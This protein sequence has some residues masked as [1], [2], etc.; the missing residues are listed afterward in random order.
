MNSNVKQPAELYEQMFYR[1]LKNCW[2]L[3]SQHEFRFKNSLYSLDASAIDLS[4]KMFPRAAHR[5]DTANV[6]LSI[7]LNHGTQV[8]EFVAL[9]D[10]Q[11]N[12][13]V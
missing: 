1:L 7:G 11:E 9:S 10:G 8:P 3:P 2:G 6:K 4:M 13:M 12:D 5:A